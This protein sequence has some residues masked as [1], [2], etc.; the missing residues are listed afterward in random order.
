MESKRDFHLQKLMHDQVYIQKEWEAA[1]R[2][3]DR[4]DNE[5]SFQCQSMIRWLLS[6]RGR[7]YISVLTFG[8]PEA[9]PLFQEILNA[10]LI[11]CV[12]F[13]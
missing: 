9:Y 1:L 5:N 10:L 2:D 11:P 13:L 4:L 3:L 7:N 6:F 8:L 12:S